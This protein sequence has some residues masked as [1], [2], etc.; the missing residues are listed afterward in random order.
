MTRRTVTLSLLAALAVLAVT[1]AAPRLL[2]AG[3]SD[4]RALDDVWARV[5]QAGAYRFSA[6]VS[7]TLAP[8]A[9]AVNAGRQPS[10]RGLYLEGRTD[11]ADQ[12]LHLTVWS[13]GGS[14]GVPASGV[15]FKVE[16]DR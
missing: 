7:Q 13:E 9:N 6:H 11:R 2:R 15:E 12:T 10:T 16:G 3:T 5:E 14:V 1:V 4:A 8:Q